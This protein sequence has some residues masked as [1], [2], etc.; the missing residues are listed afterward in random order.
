MHQVPSDRRLLNPNAPQIAK[1][2][3]V[4]KPYKYS[5]ECKPD[6]NEP[7]QDEDQDSNDPFFITNMIDHI[8]EL[9][10]QGEGGESEEKE[11]DELTEP[12]SDGDS[13]CLIAS[14]VCV[15]G[16]TCLSSLYRSK[17]F[18]TNRSLA[19]KFLLSTQ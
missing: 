5:I 1:E 7:K 17:P 3:V 10:A 6:H 13:C 11:V 15:C 9:I 8:D 19:L 4:T 14:G 16:F 18:G 2:T 12:S